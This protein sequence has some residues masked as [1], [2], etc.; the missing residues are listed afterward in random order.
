MT[1]R[2]SLIAEKDLGRWDSQPQTT[3]L[4]VE[5]ATM[6]NRYCNFFFFGTGPD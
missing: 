3:A 1:V 4:G 6:K 5:L 2:H